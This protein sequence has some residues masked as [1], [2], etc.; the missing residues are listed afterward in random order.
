MGGYRV[1]CSA[2]ELDLAAKL[3]EDGQD[4]RCS[5]ADGGVLTGEETP[6]NSGGSFCLLWCG[7]VEV[8][9]GLPIQR[10][11]KSQVGFRG[12]AFDEDPLRARLAGFSDCW[13]NLDDRLPPGQAHIPAADRRSPLQQQTPCIPALS[14][15]PARC[16]MQPVRSP[17][18]D[19]SA[20]RSGQPGAA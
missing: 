17:M 5:E 13:H 2:W 3:G 9:E 12:F 10:V 11:T 15:V 8:L 1:D 20:G 19:P 7:P 4:V 14:R 6:R 18:G 16:R